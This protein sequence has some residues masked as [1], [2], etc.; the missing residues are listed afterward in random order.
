MMNPEIKPG[1]LAKTRMVDI[2]YPNGTIDDIF[3]STFMENVIWDT[4]SSRWKYGDFNV[5]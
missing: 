1:F 2:E 3:T 4:E 5:G